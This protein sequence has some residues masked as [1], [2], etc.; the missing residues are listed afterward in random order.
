MKVF[1]RA[2]PAEE[3]VTILLQQFFLF[4]SSLFFPFLFFPSVSLLFPSAN[5]LAGKASN[6]LVTYPQQCL[7]F[8]GKKGWYRG[9]IGRF[10]SIH[11]SGPWAFHVQSSIC[12]FPFVHLLRLMVI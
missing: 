2:G 12:S 8:P 7:R 3:A 6:N 5:E 4:S 10:H 9:Q 1:F 11:V